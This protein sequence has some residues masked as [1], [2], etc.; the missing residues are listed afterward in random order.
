MKRQTKQ[1]KFNDLANAVRQIRAGEPVKR[2]GRK[3][4]SIATKPV[5]PCPDLPENTVKVDCIDWLR[6]HGVFCN[7]HDVGGGYLGD[8]TA[9]AIYGIPGS[10][11]IHGI[12]KSRNG[13]HFEIECKKGTGGILKRNQQKRMK[14]VRA[15]YAL[16]F[17][18]HGVPELEY[19]FKGLI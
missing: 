5:V 1:Q 9:Y 11:D 6:G 10:G 3:D 18:I 16:Y 17:V 12:L 14:D 8:G 4:G 2:I 19:Y 15:N 7:G 13:Q